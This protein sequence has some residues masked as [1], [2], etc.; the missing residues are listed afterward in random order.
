MQYKVDLPEGITDADMKKLAKK[1]G[2]SELHFGYYLFDGNRFHFID[3]DMADNVLNEIYTF[4]GIAM[5]EDLE[6]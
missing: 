4:F 1:H 6:E 5:P 2:N 3:H